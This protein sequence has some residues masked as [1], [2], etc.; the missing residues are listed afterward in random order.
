MGQKILIYPQVI[1]LVQDAQT[2]IKYP[3]ISW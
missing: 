2:Q 1:K 3:A